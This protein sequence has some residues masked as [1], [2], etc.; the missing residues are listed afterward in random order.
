MRIVRTLEVVFDP[1]QVNML[2]AMREQTPDKDNDT[3]VRHAVAV[4]Q[5]LLDLVD[6]DGEILVIK[7]KELYRIEMWR[8]EP[9]K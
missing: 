8:K 5:T 6:A 3:L 9:L 7:N 2:D 1:E 4:Y